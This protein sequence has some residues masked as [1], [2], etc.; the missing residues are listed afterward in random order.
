[1]RKTRTYV[2]D[3]VEYCCKHKTH[4]KFC[5]H[6]RNESAG[7]SNDPLVRA[8][9]EAGRASVRVQVYVNWQRDGVGGLEHYL[10]E[11]ES[12]GLRA[13][14]PY[15][16][17]CPLVLDEK[18][19]VKSPWYSWQGQ[20]RVSGPVSDAERDAILGVAGKEAD[21]LRYSGGDLLLHSNSL[22]RTALSMGLGQKGEEQEAA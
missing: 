12:L 19:R 8:M 22:A 18:G 6:C 5:G 1:M 16:D 3:G 2:R 21:S 10:R 20:V 11:M 14:E 13:P 9:V 15:L 17:H 7:I 4:L